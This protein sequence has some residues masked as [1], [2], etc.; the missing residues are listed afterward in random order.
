MN[1]PNNKIQTED[2][3]IPKAT[4]FTINLYFTDIDNASIDI[5]GWK[6]RFT[7]KNS[8]NDTDANA[9]IKKDIL[10]HTDPTA[11]ETE[12]SLTQTDT[13]L[14]IGTYVY[15]IVWE[16]NSTPE[17]RGIIVEGKITITKTV[18]IRTS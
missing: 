1:I 6:I 5:T 4:S 7:M 2:W 12:V 3:I 18:T 8:R 17:Q 11:G 13:D 10:T 16:D 9:V 15:D 14:S